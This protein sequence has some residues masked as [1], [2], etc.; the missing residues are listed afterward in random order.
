MTMET[1]LDTI[2]WQSCAEREELVL[3]SYGTYPSDPRTLAA[4][5]RA[6]SPARARLV[7]PEHVAGVVA[8]LYS[9]EGRMIR[10]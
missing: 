8:F 5:F 1:V 10:G 2:I 7:T 9:P 6:T 3:S 4:S